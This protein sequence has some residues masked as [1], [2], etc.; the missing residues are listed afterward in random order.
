VIQTNA[1][2]RQTEFYTFVGTSLAG[3]VN[4]NRL[5]L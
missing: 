1:T 4:N 2:Q 3:R 5:Y